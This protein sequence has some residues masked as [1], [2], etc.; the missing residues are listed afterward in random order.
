MATL[1]PNIS[2]NISFSD[3]WVYL[4]NWILAVV[5]GIS[6]VFYFPRL[7]GFV[8]SCI[9]RF[10]LWK[11][12][13]VFVS[14]HAFRI[15]PLGGRIIAT[16]IVLSNSDYTVSILRL[17]LTWRYWLS[18]MIRVSEIFFAEEDDHAEP[19]GF[20]HEANK[21]LDTSIDV[22]MDGLEIFVYNREFA[23]KNIIENLEK[24]A[25]HLDTEEG[26]ISTAS[27][28]KIFSEGDEKLSDTQTK[29]EACTKRKNNIDRH[30]HSLL[31]FLPV[32][33]RIR[34]GAIVVGNHTTP[35]ILVASFTS[36]LGNIDLAKSPCIYDKCRLNFDIDME[37][38]QV[39]MKPNISY[40]P[41]K[42]IQSSDTVISKKSARSMNSRPREHQKNLFKK[43]QKFVSRIFF[44]K[45]RESEET[46][47]EW[48]GLRRYVGDFKGEPIIELDDIEEYAKY[49]LL[50]DSASTK[51][52]YYFDIA[53]TNPNNVSGITTYPKF[54]VNVVL[55]TAAINYGSWAERQRGF[56][57]ALL[58]PHIARD[59]EVTDFVNGPGV[60]RRNEGF[61]I[62][63]K[64][65]DELVIRVPTREF[66]KDREDLKA[67]GANSQK[68]TRPFGW[69]EV[70]CGSATDISLFISYMSTVN[71]SK[72]R[73][74][75]CFSEVEVRTSVTHDL[76]FTADTHTLGGDIAFPLK[77][78]AECI[79]NFEMTSTNGV[80][81]FLGEHITLFTDLVS[82]FASGPPGKHEFFRPFVYN[83]NWVIE[84]Y[85]VYLNVNDGNVFDDSLDFES[86]SYLCFKGP[87]INMDVSIPARGSFAKYSKIDFNIST[88]K[89]D[90][91]LEVPPYHTVGS[92]MKGDKYMGT[93][94]SLVVDGYYKAYSNIEVNHNNLAYIETSADDVSLL[95][96]GYLV[97]Y[98][99]AIKENYFGEF[100]NFQ[101]NDEYLQ[102][103]AREDGRQ[104]SV[105]EE[106]KDPDYWGHYKI[107]NDLNVIFSFLV[108]KGLLVLPCQVYDYAHHIG[109][110]F[111]SLDVDIHL[112]SYYMDLQTDFSPAECHYLKPGVLQSKN[113]VFDRKAYVDFVS[114]R[115]PEFVIDTFSL[116]THRMLGLDLNTYQCKWDFNAGDFLING[117]PMCLTGLLAGLLAF[118][119]GFRD[120]ENTHKYVVPIIYD[121]ANFSF[122]CPKIEAKFTT[123]LEESYFRVVAT[124]ILVS[125]NDV[126]NLRYSDRITVLLP[127]IIA[128]IVDL[129]DESHCMYLRT[130]LVFNDI[131][132]KD[133]ML[134]H[135]SEQQG[136]VRR[137]DAPTH[138]APFVLFPENRDQVYLD[139]YGS[140][141]PLVSLPT[142]SK[143][144]DSEDLYCEDDDISL[145][146]S[147]DES[148][149][150][151]DSLLDEFIEPTIRYVD[152][153]FMPQ[154]QPVPG[155]KNDAFI[156][157]LEP[158][159][160]FINPQAVI[161][162][163][164]LALAL[165]ILD[166]D[167]LI[168]RLHCETV[169]SI[170]KLIKLASMI[171][172]I[173]FVCPS[174]NIKMGAENSR[175]L[176]SMLS[177]APP[178]PVV[179]LSAVNPSIVAKN[180]VLKVRSNSNVIKE[181][182]MSFAIHA[183]EI[184]ISQIFPN[185]VN[186][187]FSFL[188]K[189]LE[190]WV[191]KTELHGS[192]SSSTLQELELAVQEPLLQSSLEFILR[193]YKDLKP[194]ISNFEEFAEASNNWRK[195]LAYLLSPEA[196]ILELQLDSKVITKPS[197]LHRSV[198]DHV[199]FFD[200]W[201]VV[202]K[203]RSL[204]TD[205]RCYDEA[206]QKFL[207]R[208]W[209]VPLDGLNIVYTNFKSWRAWEG[210]LDERRRFFE[211]IF[212]K[213]R[214]PDLPWNIS[215]K[216]VSVAVSL[217]DLDDCKD[218][219]SIRELDFDLV[220]KK[221]NTPNVRLS[222]DT[223]QVEK[224][225]TKIVLKVLECDLS[226][227]QRSFL[228]AET[229]I[230]RINRG[231]SKPKTPSHSAEPSEKRLLF[232]FGIES[233]HFH[234]ALIHT[235]YNF[236][237]QGTSCMLQLIQNSSTEHERFHLSMNSGQNDISAGQGDVDFLTLNTRGVSL[238]AGASISDDPVYIVDFDTKE[239]NMEVRDQK[240]RFIQFLHCINE[241]IKLIEALNLNLLNKP[242]GAQ[243]E[244]PAVQRT[245][246]NKPKEFKLSIPNLLIRTECHKFT[247]YTDIVLPL[248]LH[249]VAR[250]GTLQAAVHNSSFE[251]E[252]AYKNLSVELVVADTPVIR[253]ESSRFGASSQLEELHE[254]WILKSSVNLGY[255]KASVQLFFS[256]SEVLL[257]HKT[258]LEE[259]ILALQD[260]ASVFTK[261][262]EVNE[263]KEGELEVIAKTEPAQTKPPS[264]IAFDLHINQEYCGFLT[265]KDLCRYSVELEE[266]NILLTNY[267]KTL[268]TS[269]LTVPVY[270]DASCSAA[271][272]AILDPLMP[273]GLST[274]IDLNLSAKVLNDALGPSME[275]ESQSIQFVSEY[276]RVCL[277]P[278]ILYKLVEFSE[279][280]KKLIPKYE[281]LLK[282]SK[283]SKEL[284][285]NGAEGKN[286]TSKAGAEAGK[287]SV[288]DQPFPKKLSISSIHVLSYNFCVGWLFGGSYK[289]YP[290]FICGAERLFAVAKSDI[291][292]L[293]MMGG[294]F[295]VANGST[296]SSFF[297]T[298]SEMHGL[299]RAFMPKL[300]INYFVDEARK[301]WI[302]IKGDE[303]DARFM[304]NLK[305]AIERTVKSIA[306]V[307]K[308]LETKTK[309]AEMRSKLIRK[310]SNSASESPESAKSFR[311]DF[312]GVE[313]TVGFAGSKIFLYRLQD[314]DFNDIPSS[315]TLH[316]PAVLTVL[317]YELR[318]EDERKH[319]MK[320]EMLISRSDNTLFPSCVPVI[321]D[322]ASTFKSLFLS[323]Q[324]Q[325]AVTVKESKNKSEKLGTGLNDFRRILKTFDFHVGIQIE[326]Q[327]VSL[328]CE[329]VAKVAAVVEFD[330]ASITLSSGLKS[331]DTVHA[332]AKI[333][334]ISASLQHIYSDERSGTIEV[335]SILFSNVTSLVPP[336]ENFASI[337]VVGI[338]GYVKMKQYQD[339]DIFSD[340][341][342]PS[343]DAST[344]NLADL[345][346]AEK[347]RPEKTAL[348]SRSG[349]KFRETSQAMSTILV[350]IDFIVSKVFIEV[351]F[352]SALGTVKL[353]IDS[354]WIISL[355]S[356]A[357]NYSLN[358]GLQTLSVEFNGRLGGYLK[359]NKLFLNSSI[360]WKIGDLPVLDVPLIHMSGGF[361]QISLKGIFDDHV[362][363]FISLTSWFF[364]VYNRKNG[365][366]IS[367]DHL[368]VR[369]S[370]E[371]V[372][373][374]LTS[375]SA[376][377]FYDIYNTINRMIEENKT[378]YREILK[379]SNEDDVVDAKMDAMVAEDMRKLETRIEV[380][381]GLTRLQVFPHSFVDT[382]VFV[383]ECDLSKA[384]FAQN[385]YSLGVMNQIELQLNNVIASFSTTPGTSEE[386]ID[387]ADVD[388]FVNYVGKAKGGEIISLP[389]FMI[390]MRTYQKFETMQI[391]YVFQSSFG[392]TVNIRWNLGSV[393]CV[394][395]MY[396]AHKRALLSRTEATSLRLESTRGDSMRSQNNLDI[397]D[398]ESLR[399]LTT[400]S[401]PPN[402]GEIHKD[403]DQDIQDTLEKVSTKSKY[404]YKALAPPIIEAPQLREL[405]NATP[406]LEWFGLHRNK[407]PDAV[408][409]LAIVALQ[410]VIN[411]IEQQYSKTLGKA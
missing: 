30:D 158:I 199:R 153:D 213:E 373:V 141:Y 355:K 358:L 353:G 307:Q 279:G 227:S 92:F 71:G 86:N 264:K 5:L 189:D 320:A 330:G 255:F 281:A 235:N 168:D 318:K 25:K 115:S 64:T 142:A 365:I 222:V 362:F 172:N 237:S 275:I 127:K 234:L 183:E 403:F 103:I 123:E 263:K 253:T 309:T 224:P 38:F 155:Q 126:A 75:V 90:I 197:R 149:N 207:G 252:T 379:D 66:S 342:F 198:M 82:D 96:Y 313:I 312:S 2:T 83:L 190:A 210:N 95:F 112:T 35:H 270:G 286:I 32:G 108:R 291:G 223:E 202:S 70:T 88:P 150:G 41:D 79:W 285:S 46:S 176:L 148:S 266:I 298:S 165:Q 332:V 346:K 177:S 175:D 122:R 410:K 74:D 187:A 78:N 370:Y 354:A 114:D 136:H 393:N 278:L 349:N 407:F 60:Q 399:S 204:L 120:F 221:M 45:Q 80:I 121:A 405:G 250:N 117:D 396:A 391:E 185:T 328:S 33:I 236:Y 200:S 402:P 69:I 331:S 193:L 73:L 301:L 143:P 288:S 94:G 242:E 295:S 89:L 314:N 367:K 152:E 211:S 147:G 28:E 6:F 386:F 110:L 369:I 327:K 395:D 194:A 321:E 276:F 392:G 360:E 220:E 72:N 239:V 99:F 20:T 380:S 36:A 145:M 338:T 212:L 22:L 107:E 243:E 87:S 247:L 398:R 390:S 293:T 12:Y 206:K 124:D 15:S 400:F 62:S 52:L 284:N 53:G 68:Q 205:I 8:L 299:N 1:P 128:E 13:K 341:W 356:S 376:S 374:S 277:S 27:E 85:R 350:Q 61:E 292:K 139:A 179:T 404:T 368:H 37:K 300:Q 336:V 203:F 333:Q 42:Y 268:D 77:W 334:S 34:R 21:S 97:R 267:D 217:L 4:A 272:V 287:D 343:G 57:Q 17:N 10:T 170:I 55:T 186:N 182:S 375:L 397:E 132:Q 9:L 65:T 134:I 137:N 44:R 215:F 144:L 262:I 294:Y 364:D 167:F 50:L 326:P 344:E 283:N 191:S 372:N 226:V 311:P 131:C 340:I 101:T 319:L 216:I 280:L 7:V 290:G 100:K 282:S 289:D 111:N 352:G 233:F 315:L 323:S 256:A 188:L 240:R 411:E 59:G 105:T 106:G 29:E 317:L 151:N 3:S 401:D 406:P 371:A 135:R 26:S 324:S 303:L 98:F 19:S 302:N 348:A 246:E 109:I 214:E 387:G 130:S 51:I 209:N 81:F 133:T 347:A 230:K 84:N 259:E 231:Q 181:T 385:E 274:M 382:K 359:L 366:D 351:D 125:F 49:S 245:K 228:L 102:T 47:Q 67:N 363:A 261:N 39:S 273:V 31:R 159:D 254:L 157:E 180:S 265:Y 166:L 201:K 63:I 304:S 218:F 16:N 271:R 156:L 116:H 14:F 345:K 322:F 184:R 248:K 208:N 91:Y 257:K 258:T 297:S 305:I 169:K 316:C 388:E 325:K 339:V 11:H 260:A 24:M 174:V 337:S 378:S 357:W 58:F 306:D 296:A 56:I 229:V 178:I 160:G 104:S 329:P 162:L 173:R 118:M 54:G 154:T 238:V 310:T 389:K 163:S 308:F 164:E 113:I 23:Y 384:S 146:T 76:L 232:S 18:S 219:L 93:T 249:I 409:Q 251:I 381:T 225:N 40:N 129:K 43:G 48:R 269:S 241:D 161:C 138:R 192:I 394:R 196:A 377:D 408:H 195:Q 335:R 361:G 119:L 140:R 244:A 383:L 171:D